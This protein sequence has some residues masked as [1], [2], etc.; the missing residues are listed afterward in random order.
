MSLIINI[1]MYIAFLC[2]TIATSTQSWR[3]YDAAGDDGLTSWHTDATTGWRDEATATTPSNDGWGY[4]S[5]SQGPVWAH[6]ATTVSSKYI[7]LLVCNML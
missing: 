2:S 5:T 4:A 6:D 1:I 3:W 7:S